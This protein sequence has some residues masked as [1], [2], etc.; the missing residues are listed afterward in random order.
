MDH[1]EPKRTDAIPFG[2]ESRSDLQE[3]QMRCDEIGHDR[4]NASRPLLSP[5]ESPREY[6][7]I[8][9]CTLIVLVVESTTV[10]VFHFR[11]Q[12]QSNSPVQEVYLAG[13]HLYNAFRQM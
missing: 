12:C 9:S 5:E 11:K 10:P 1:P 3:P 13:L 8:T 6:F 2:I 7:W 4:F